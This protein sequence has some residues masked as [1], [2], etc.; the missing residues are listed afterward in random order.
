[1]LLL[2]EVEAI[3]INLSGNV[4]ANA[5]VGSGTLLT[6]ITKSIVGLGNVDDYI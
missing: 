4:K 5:F 3:Q 6:G 2:V 1:M